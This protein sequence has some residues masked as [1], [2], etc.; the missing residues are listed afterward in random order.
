[1]HSDTSLTYVFAKRVFSHRHRVAP[2][3]I[4]IHEAHSLIRVWTQ[5]DVHCHDWSKAR[6]QRT[7]SRLMQVQQQPAD[8]NQTEQ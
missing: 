6:T 1:M 8:R 4:F 7:S 3:S 2:K 5:R